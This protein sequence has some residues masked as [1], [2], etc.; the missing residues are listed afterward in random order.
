MKKKVQDTGVLVGAH[1]EPGE[2][3][4]WEFLETVGGLRKGS[5]SLCGRPVRGRS[6]GDPEGAQGTDITP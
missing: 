5:I 3:V 4:N 6:C 2:S 1:W